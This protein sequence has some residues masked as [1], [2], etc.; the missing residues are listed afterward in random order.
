MNKTNSI[1]KRIFYVLVFLTFSNTLFAQ[2]YVNGNF[3]FVGSSAS[4]GNVEFGPNADVQV[5][6]GSEFFILGTS[7]VVNTGAEF[8]APASPTGKFIYQGSTQQNISGGNSAAI[9]GAQPSLVNIEINNSNNV[10]LSNTNTRLTSGIEFTNGHLLLGSQ[11]LELSSD[12]VVTNANES[13]YVVTNGN[14]F[15]AKENLA[16]SSTFAFPVG[17]AVADFTPASITNTGGSADNYF[18]QVKSYSESAS[19]E[20][21]ASNGMDRT[22][23]IYSSNGSAST[24]ALQHNSSSNGASYTDADAFV[25]QYQGM[26]WVS[27]AQQNQGVWQIGTGAIGTDAAGTVVGSRVHH[28]AYASTA[29][30]SSANEAFFSKSSNELAPLPVTLIDFDANKLG[31]NQSLVTWSTSSEMNSSHF[32]VET[33]VDGEVWMKI[34]EVKA[35]EVSYHITN[36]QFIHTN[37]IIGYNYYRINMVDKDGSEEFSNIKFVLFNKP[38]SSFSGVSVYPNPTNG[39]LNISSFNK[40]NNYTLTDMHGKTLRSFYMQSE[41]TDFQEDLSM[42]ANGVYY[43]KTETIMGEVNVFKIILN[44]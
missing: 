15:L 35:Q 39:L 10:L 2:F 5:Y 38:N 1:L 37:P 29:T 40:L 14:G 13:R 28:R 4:F 17:R 21:V 16:T 43:V 11:N 12:A 23:N 19:A 31:K 36:Y 32:D 24:I 25:T 30:T 27:S 22:W 26:Q 18:V 33:S 34:G 44:K 3:A 8:T 41:N 7:T 20:T 42:Y 6:N 9:G